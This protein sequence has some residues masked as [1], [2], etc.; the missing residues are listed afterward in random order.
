[1][2][3]GGGDCVDVCVYL[4]GGRRYMDVSAPVMG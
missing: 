2:W 3:G 1:M 4:D